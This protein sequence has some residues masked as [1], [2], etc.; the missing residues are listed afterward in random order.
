MIFLL[1]SIFCSVVTVSFFKLFERFN[2]DTFQAIVGN[3]FVCV[4][5]GN[6]ISDKHIITTDFWDEPW[7]L[8][9][10]LLG[11]LFVTIFYCIAETT[12]KLGVS[13]SMVAAKLSVVVPVLFAVLAYNES[14]SYIKVGGII[15]SL[16]SV[17]LI[18]KKEQTIDHI[19]KTIWI[20]PV[21]V[22]AGSG[23]ID[24]LIKYIESRFIPKSNA[25][26]ILSTAFLAAY[27]L[28]MFFMSYQNI[29]YRKQID[30]KNILWGFALGIPNYF[31]M[32]F[33]VKTLENFNASHIFPI[34]NIG[35]VAFSTITSLLFF[36]EKLSKTNFIG[37]ALA[38]FSILLIS[39]N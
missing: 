32:F 9:T 11:F 31:S 35:I 26:D 30:T 28:G 38:I 34:N 36:R 4:V 1:L 10:L 25:G 18:S 23:I 13:V 19:K 17:Y 24:T 29:R 22:F 33:L 20:L 39:L 5:I 3:Y 2:V 37:L 21:I 12:Q 7:F 8:F 16:F 6:L 27:F 15:L 14:I